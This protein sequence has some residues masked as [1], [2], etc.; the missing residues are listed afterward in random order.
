MQIMTVTQ[1]AI[2]K[3]WMILS[4]LKI[5]HKSYSELA[6]SSSLRPLF[7]LTAAGLE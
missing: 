1:D 3:I 5:A 7:R 6:L 2:N 4:T